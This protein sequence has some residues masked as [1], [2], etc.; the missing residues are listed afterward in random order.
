M[1]R[2]FD[3]F[4]VN[5]VMTELLRVPAPGVANTLIFPVSINVLGK[6]ESSPDYPNFGFS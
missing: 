4:H 1:L 6:A 3:V 2:H 5:S